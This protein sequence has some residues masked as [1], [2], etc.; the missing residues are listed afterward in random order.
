MVEAIVVAGANRRL[1]PLRGKIAE[2]DRTNLTRAPQLVKGSEA[3]G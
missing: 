3:V 1:D 2:A